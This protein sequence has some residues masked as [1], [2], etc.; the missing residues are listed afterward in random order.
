MPALNSGYNRTSSF[1]LG[2]NVRL[3]LI[4]GS[5]GNKGSVLITEQLQVFGEKVARYDIS[6]IEDIVASRVKLRIRP[7]WWNITAVLILALALTF[8][9]SIAGFVIAVL[10]TVIGF[11][12]IKFDKQK[13]DIRLADGN[14]VSVTGSKRAMSRLITL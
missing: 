12:S 7:S 8:F 9:L 1:C 13:V 4:G 10:V 11:I 6:D 3:R 5:F 2:F 14:F